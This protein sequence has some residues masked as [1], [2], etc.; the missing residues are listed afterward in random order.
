MDCFRICKVKI[1]HK[2]NP[3]NPRETTNTRYNPVL[4]MTLLNHVLWILIWDHNSVSGSWVHI[5]TS[6]TITFIF[7][8]K[9]SFSKHPSIKTEFF[10]MYYPYFSFIFQ[11]S[12][13]YHFSL[14]SHI[15]PQVL[16]DD[17]LSPKKMKKCDGVDWVYFKVDVECMTYLQ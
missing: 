12:K 3:W 4:I 17:H 10:G 5:Q 11:I 15:T 1:H 16:V 7:L 6:L 8:N 14:E 9:P 2:E 13:K